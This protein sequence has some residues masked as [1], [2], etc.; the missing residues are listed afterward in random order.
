MRRAPIPGLLT[1]LV[2]CQGCAPRASRG[3]DPQPPSDESTATAGRSAS[4][5]P[6]P[7]PAD[8]RGAAT[9]PPAAPPPPIAPPSP[10]NQACVDQAEFQAYASALEA[11]ATATRDREL[12]TLGAQ[13]LSR[14]GFTVARPP[15][16][17]YEVKGRRFAVVGS[18]TPEY[19]PGSTRPAIVAK[20][21]NGA[22]HPFEPRVSAYWL[23]FTVCGLS[24]DPGRGVQERAPEPLVIELAAGETLGAPLRP[25]YEIWIARADRTCH[26]MEPP[27]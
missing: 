18:A 22:I 2:V 3:A 15:G 27:S 17:T 16:P 5:P 1:W 21:R 26:G 13:V 14:T 23:T 6:D 10:G 9:G 8:P 11:L 25:T 24:C 12:A 20:G 7:T 19:L 4:E